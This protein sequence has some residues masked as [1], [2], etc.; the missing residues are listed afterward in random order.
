MEMVDQSLTD[1][2]L[3]D[4]PLSTAVSAFNGVSMS[5][6]RRGDS[7]RN[8][9]AATIAQ[10]YLRLKKT[11]ENK[12]EL[13]ATME[14]EFAR[15]R[16]GYR[17]RYLA[18]LHSSS[19]CVSSFIAGP[20]N[21][22]AARMNKRADIA[23]KRLT[24]FL[25]FRTRALEAINRTLHPELRPIMSGDSDACERLKAEIE[26]AELRQARM[27]AINKAHKAFLK[28]ADTL[29]ASP[30]SDETKDRIRNYKPQYSWE[31]HPIAPFE[32]SNLSANIRRMKKRLESITAAKALPETKLDGANAR[33]E[34][35]PGENRIKL[36]FPGKPSEEVRSRL[37]SG[38]FRWS[39]TIGAWQAYRNHRTIETAKKEAGLELEVAIAKATKQ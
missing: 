6:E 14:A 33:I 36:F 5:P 18:Y 10:D 15:Y 9:Y 19:R 29:N 37:K 7:T 16:D 39:P 24:E 17:R 28:N 13:Q 21:F 1:K 23:H 31:P 25:E 27:L 38:G 11:V 34:D 4:I 22:P 8:E 12:P 26:E 30:L 20:S 2:F 32:F 3:S 35:C